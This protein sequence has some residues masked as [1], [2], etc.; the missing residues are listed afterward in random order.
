[1]KIH[2][3]KAFTLNQNSHSDTISVIQVCLFIGILGTFIYLFFTDELKYIRHESTS[4]RA[5][6]VS[7]RRF[8]VGHRLYVQTGKCDF[9]YEQKKYIVRFKTKNYRA[10]GYKKEFEIG[11][12]ITLKI[13]TKNPSITKFRH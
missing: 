6:I 2:R 7:E 3:K 8:H 9:V 4:I 13:S 11:D 10:I 5:K 12:I 1:M